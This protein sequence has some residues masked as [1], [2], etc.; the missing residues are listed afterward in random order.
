MASIATILGAMVAVTSVF[1]ALGPI[2]AG[3]VYDATGAYS[4]IFVAYIVVDCLAA[5]LVYFMGQQP[6]RAALAERA[7]LEESE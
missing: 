6:S 5:G 7:L 3:F 4:S 2:T 1:N